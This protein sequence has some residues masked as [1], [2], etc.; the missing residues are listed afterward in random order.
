L[1]LPAVVVGSLFVV[2]GTSVV[3]TGAETQ[4]MLILLCYAQF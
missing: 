2:V 4:N 3:V 1:R